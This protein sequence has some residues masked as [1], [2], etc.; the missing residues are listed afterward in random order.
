[1][2]PFPSALEMTRRLI[3]LDS[4][5]PPGRE[6]ACALYLGGLLEKAGWSVQRLDLAPG[7]PVPVAV[8]IVRLEEPAGRPEGQEGPL[9]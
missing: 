4:S 5:N 3:S 9:I 8:D 1:M 6:E 2:E 7:R